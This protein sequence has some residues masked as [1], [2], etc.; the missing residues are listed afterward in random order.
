MIKTHLALGAAVIAGVTIGAISTNTQ[1]CHAR[2]GGK[3]PD[4][5]CTPGTIDPRVTQA[6]IHSTI[7]VSGYTGV[8]RPGTSVTNRLK[9]QGIAAYGY[10]DTSMSDYEEDHL[11]SL[12]LG[13]APADPKNLWPESPRSPNA[14]DR[15][16]NLLH[17]EVCA[18]T[19][20]LS[21]AQREVS[22][23]WTAVKVP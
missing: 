15:V 5:A 9:R 22:T 23:D 6:N 13:G 1:N 3:L 14:K 11:I 21:T 19:I 4:A 20:R 18:G 2:D 8:V 16:E 10:A 12:E 7:C 17:R